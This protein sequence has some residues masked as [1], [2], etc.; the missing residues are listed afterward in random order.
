[1]PKI[2][3]V[4]VLLSLLASPVQAG[5]YPDFLAAAK[6]AQA[7]HSKGKVKRAA[8]LTKEAL[9]LLADDARYKVDYQFRLIEQYVFL[10]GGTFDQNRR[11]AEAMRPYFER[12]AIET[13]MG[14]ERVQNMEKAIFEALKGRSPRQKS[15]AHKWRRSIYAQVTADPWILMRLKL[16][17]VHDMRTDRSVI[18]TRR[19]YKEILEQAKQIDAKHEIVRDIEI[20][21]AKVYFERRNHER[22]RADLQALVDTW[23]SWED[24]PQL[25]IITAMGLIAGSYAEDDKQ[26]KMQ[27]VFESMLQLEKPRACEPIAIYRR[28]PQVQCFGCGRDGKLVVEYDILPTGYLDGIKILAD[29]VPRGA[30]DDIFRALKDWR[31]YPAVENGQPVR[32]SGRRV[33]FSVMGQRR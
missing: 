10:A 22:A 29:E 19:E 3:A 17:E 7:A 12:L 13:K 6:A 26:V 8:S 4:L 16:N 15:R 24:P 1:M 25:S 33:Q 32:T 11:A 2:T 20:M 23:L 18:R 31:Y 27:E 9:E 14:D 21:I 5:E 30:K 28:E